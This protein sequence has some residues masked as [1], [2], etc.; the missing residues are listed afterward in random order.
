MLTLRESLSA[1]T[2]A[3]I[4]EPPTQRRGLARGRL[5][6]PLGDAVRAPRGQLGD[7][8]AAARR[9]EDAARPLPDGRRRDP[10]LGAADDRR[11]T[12]SAT[13]PS[14]RASA[15][16][17]ARGR[18]AEDQRAALDPAEPRSS[19]APAAPPGPGGQHANVTASR[20][21]AVFDVEASAVLERGAAGAAAR[22]RR[23]GD[24]RRRPG[25]P[26]PVAQPRA[27]A[28]TAGRARSPRRCGCRAAAARPG[29]PGPRA[30]AGSRQKRRTGERKRGRRRPGYEGGLSGRGL[31]ERERS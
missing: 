21:E 15:A 14:W 29:R 12:S 11:R 2:I 4:G 20:V 27:G 16:T 25:R 19:C 31:R 26:R 3:K 1:G 5:A 28:G 22:A 6:A 23:P 24:H 18:R 9:P 17:G 30:S 7:R 10:A 8:R 13:S